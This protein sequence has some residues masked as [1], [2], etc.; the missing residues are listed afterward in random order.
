MTGHVD[1]LCALLL[2]QLDHLWVLSRRDDHLRQGRLVAVDD[3]VYLVFLEH[4]QVR[5]RFDRRGGAKQHVG[6]FRGD[7][8]AT[9]AVADRGSQAVQDQV[10]RVIVHADVGPVHRFHDLP[11]HTARVDAQFLPQFNTLCW[12]APGEADGALLVAKLG[13]DSSG[14][15]QGDLLLGPPLGWDLVLYG[16]GM[17]L[18]LVLDLVAAGL[19]LS[20]QEKR[21]G[22]VP[23][24]VRVGRCPGGDHAQQ[25][26]GYD[27]IGR[28]PTDPLLGPCVAKRVDAAGAHGAVPAADPQLPIATM[29]FLCLEPVPGR[30]IPLLLGDTQH[31]LAGWIDR[32]LYFLFLGCHLA[33][34]SLSLWCFVPVPARLLR[35]QGD[36]PFQVAFH[37]RPPIRP[38][39]NADWHP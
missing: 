18:R 17:Q 5:L 14:Q 15:V 7:H 26:A 25:A 2:R 1:A 13:I 8:R 23:P 28:G 19:A 30:L 9:P 16:Q 10:N 38:W 24:V 11:V 34:P 6:Q 3:D 31:V 12:R 32:T 35:W 21:V 39:P 20:R 29:G 33:I 4:T 27:G 37:P 36:E 22:D